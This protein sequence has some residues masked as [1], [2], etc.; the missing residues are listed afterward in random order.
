MA[1]AGSYIG[2]VIG[3]AVGV[4]ISGSVLGQTSR[5]G[6]HAPNGQLLSKT[7]AVGWKAVSIAVTT[8]AGFL[9]GPFL[10]AFLIDN[11]FLGGL[12]L[13]GMIYV[14]L[15]REIDGWNLF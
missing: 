2:A 12:L 1:L 13:I 14:G 5:A 7:N 11:P 15:H 6:Y 4:V 9:F 10:Y 8:V 3:F